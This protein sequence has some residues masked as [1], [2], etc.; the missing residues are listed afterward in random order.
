MLLPVTAGRATDGTVLIRPTGEVDVSNAYQIRE[1][2]DRALIGHKPSAI[3]IDLSRVT[4]IDSIGIG[5]LVACYHA[6]AACRV[7]LAARE[8]NCTVYRQLWI[9][10]LV[11]LFGLAT[12][13][14]DRD[15]AATGSAAG[16]G[17]SVPG[18]SVPLSSVPP[19]SVPRPSMPGTSVPVPAGRDR[20]SALA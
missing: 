13:G 14:R 7:P 5:V 15:A 1:A 6:A 2:V 4:L 17:A 16:A 18:P 20:E 11:G 19:S 3:V 12:P 10:G 8:P 9:A